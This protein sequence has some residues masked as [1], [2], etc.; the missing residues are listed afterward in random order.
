MLQ[1]ELH[2]ASVGG[3]ADSGAGMSE[4]TSKVEG[5]CKAAITSTARQSQVVMAKAANAVTTTMQTPVHAAFR[6]NFEQVLV[7]Q[8]ASGAFCLNSV[9]S[10]GKSLTSGP[11]CLPKTAGLST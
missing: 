10:G 1:N 5:L 9:S 7:P 2:E 6:E 8:F 4:L 11:L 3:G